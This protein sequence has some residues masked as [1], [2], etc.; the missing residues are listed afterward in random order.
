M[1]TILCSYTQAGLAVLGVGSNTT[2]L[3]RLLR[4]GGRYAPCKVHHSSLDSVGGVC[5]KE[6]EGRVWVQGGSLL[7]AHGGVC[8]LG[9]FS[10]FRKDVRQSVCRGNTYSIVSQTFFSGATLKTDTASLLKLC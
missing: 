3:L 4:Y 6:P 10:T 7:L 5:V 2:L 8:V 9:D 1:Y